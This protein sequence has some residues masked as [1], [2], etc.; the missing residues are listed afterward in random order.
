[1]GVGARKSRPVVEAPPL[2]GKPKPQGV[3]EKK[4][5]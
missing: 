3:G 4:I 2:A 1:M 5:F